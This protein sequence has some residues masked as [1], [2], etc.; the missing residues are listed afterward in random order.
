MNLQQLEYIVALDTWRH[1][2]T[3]AE[4]CN[5]TQPTLSMMIQRLEDELDVKIFDRSK[6]P[7]VT[8]AI[9]DKII[10]QARVVLNETTQMKN[11]VRDQKNEAQGE[12]H[13]GIIPTV[14]PYLLPLFLHDFLSKY[15]N[16]RLKIS[17]LTT[18]QIISHLE[19]QQM[20]AAILATPLKNPSIKEFPLFYEQF[21][22]YASAEEKMMKKKYLLAEDINVNHLWLLEEGHCLREQVVNLCELK[23]KET[24]LQN[25]DYQAGS[26]ETLRKMVDINNGITILP[27]L[28]LRDLST[29]QKKNIRYF[30]PPAP[31]REVSIVTYRYFV[32]YHLIDLLK[33]EIIKNI[34]APM[35]SPDRKQITELDK[36][37]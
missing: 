18:D 14:A 15:P 30:K 21:V 8:T 23:R 37:K 35:L 12:L 32:K 11:L 24:L 16:V 5:V 10:E 6:Q 19:K 28:A 27:E 31:V 26:I 3:A 29:K 33:N 20:D 25:L 1:F 7:V 36:R 4:K 2:S 17:E 9:G 22:V 34:P 13:V